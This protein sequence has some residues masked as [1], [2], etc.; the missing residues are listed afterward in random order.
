M[1]TASKSEEKIKNK[2][3]LLYCD[4]TPKAVL[5]WD[6][7][8]GLTHYGRADALVFYKGLFLRS[9][10]RQFDYPAV[11][12]L[13]QNYVKTKITPSRH[14]IYARDNFTCQYCGFNPRSNQNTKTKN[15]LTLDHVVP[16]YES[17]KGKV[18]SQYYKKYVSTEGWKNKVTCC[19]WCNNAKDHQSLE[20]SGLVLQRYPYEPTEDEKINL[21][22]RMLLV[23]PEEWQPFLQQG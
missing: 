18:Y 10:Q 20:S 22:F 23:L 7:A 3:L 17:F 5:R 16:L 4:G 11:I 8:F 21:M 2:V 6:E 1:K 14:N 9:A 12:I 15:H 19:R 13:K